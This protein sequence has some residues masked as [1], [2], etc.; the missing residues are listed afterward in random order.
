[1]KGVV[2]QD[3]KTFKIMDVPIVSPGENK[4]LIKVKACGICGTDIH[5]YN[6]EFMPHFP[7]I[8]GHEF[9][10]IVEETGK[11]ID[12]FKEG[13]RVAISPDIYCG[14]CSNC[15]KGVEKYCENWNSIGTTIDGAFAEF[16][17]VPEKCLY[18]LPEN[19]T[20]DDG[21]LLELASC[22]YSGVR[23]ISE[24]YDK[25]VLLLGAGSI[26]IV[27]L[28]S[29]LSQRPLQLDILDIFD[30]K[31]DF[32]KKIGADNI[33]NVIK[34]KSDFSELI[35]EK[36]DV[37]VDCTGVPNVLEKAF[38]LLKKN[39]YFIFFGVC[40]SPASIQ[41]SPYLIYENSWKIIGVYP[42]MRSYG[43]IIDLVSRGILDFKPIISHRFK[44][45]QFIEAFDLLMNKDSKARKI[46]IYP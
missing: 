26:G 12:K 13:D 19:M 8:L 39:A 23:L 44:L 31:L 15:R 18:H 35:K 5:A 40:P 24:Y 7:L 9:S 10:G 17:T 28:I 37:V 14:K 4:V 16:I 34:I 11:S 46:L 33:Y 22:V 38:S 6:G 45:G 25:K 29:L 36:Y 41:V 30:N 20:F 3:V 2:L 1:M 32:A 43:S 42:D 21:A 27:Y